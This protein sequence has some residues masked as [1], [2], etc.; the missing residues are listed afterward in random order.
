MT[1][2]ILVLDDNPDIIQTLTNL[3][4]KLGLDID[5][6]S[7]GIECIKMYKNSLEQNKKY[8]LIIADLTIP[9]GMGG[10]DTIQQ[11]IRIDPK[12]KAILS[13]GYLQELTELKIKTQIPIEILTKPY[14]LEELYKKL[15]KMLDY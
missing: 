14:S 2:S 11:L 8:N 9:G 7:N 15:K 13:S 4:K 3:C 10:L 1:G 6:C 5:S 12:I